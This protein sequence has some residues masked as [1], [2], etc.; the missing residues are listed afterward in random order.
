[1]LRSIYEERAVIGH[2]Q[3][4]YKTASISRPET[5]PLE[6]PACNISSWFGVWKLGF[7]EYSPHSLVDSPHW[8]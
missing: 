6:R 4:W 1:M 2:A 5:P 3:P 7:Q 8:A